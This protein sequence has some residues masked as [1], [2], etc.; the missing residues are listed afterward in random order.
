VAETRGVRQPRA[1]H[2]GHRRRATDDVDLRAARGGGV[3]EALIAEHAD[4]GAPRRV[5]GSRPGA[6]RKE[7]GRILSITML[8]GGAIGPD[9][10]RRH[11]RGRSDGGGRRG[12]SRRPRGP[13]RLRRAWNGVQT[14]VLHHRHHF[15]VLKEPIDPYV[16]PG[17]S[18]QRRAAAH[19]HRTARRLR[20]GRRRSRP[21]ASACA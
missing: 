8:S 9:V 10:H 5:A 15:G 7:G 14:G 11:L 4:S 21:I 20:R 12:L 17:R 1:G 19:Q 3:F 13:K 18:V 16:I 2:A 6:S